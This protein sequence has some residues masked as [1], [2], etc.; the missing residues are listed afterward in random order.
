MRHV[1]AS[2]MCDIA[3]SSV[4]DGK[5]SSETSHD[6]SMLRNLPDVTD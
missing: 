1:H 3:H 2:Y 4:F 5:N 6:L